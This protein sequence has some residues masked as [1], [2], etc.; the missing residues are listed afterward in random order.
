MRARLAMLCLLFGAIPAAAST[1]VGAVDFFRVGDA[2][3]DA[4]TEDCRPLGGKF[5]RPDSA[6]GSAIAKG[7]YYE[8]V[9]KGVHIDNQA[10]LLGIT[11]LQ[12]ALVVRSTEITEQGGSGLGDWY[13]PD[14]ANAGRVVYYSDDVRRGQFLNFGQ[15]V[16][17][18]PVQYGGGPV[19]ISLFAIEVDSKDDNQ[20]INALFGTLAALGKRVT[21]PLSPVF[22]VLETLGSSLIA[23]NR[24]DLM[25]RYDTMA[26]STMAARTE[27]SALFLRYG[28]Y[29]I[30]RDESRDQPT[31]AGSL[32]YKPSTRTLFTDARCAKGNEFQRSYGI[33]QLNQ[34]DRAVDLQQQK[35]KALRDAIDAV[36]NKDT[37]AL[38]A[39]AGRLG[40]AVEGDAVYKRMSDALIAVEAADATHLPTPRQIGQLK[41]AL[42][43][44]RVAID[45]RDG[46]GKKDPN[47]HYPSDSQIETLLARLQR[48]VGDG[49]AVEDNFDPDVVFKEMEKRW[50]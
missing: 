50:H 46:T 3:G 36:S 4:A 11:R 18:G 2:T 9:L 41:T 27:L 30:V 13:G 12:L 43:D 16:I 23:G 32:Y 20:K 7:E 17:A 39:A 1:N 22:G 38:T 33:V 5:S 34:V 35:F 21:T 49:F 45:A 8:V 19:M 14:S 29:V 15:I 24:D 25:M 31:D 6:K 26:R 28:D 37:E 48:S 40:A 44:L 10:T 42:A 47:A